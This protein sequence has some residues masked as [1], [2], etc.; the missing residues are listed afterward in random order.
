M[1]EQAVLPVQDRQRVG[2]INATLEHAFAT[3]NV[4]AFLRKVQS[5]G[6]RVRDFEGILTLGLLGTGSSALYGA[7][8]DS[9]RGQVRER[10]L[11]SV[12]RVA[13]EYRA[14]YLKIYAYY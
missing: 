9:D 1:F 14:K 7:L 2:E 10:Y 8:A 11:A 6:L 4:A 5:A 13:P 3:G 12:E